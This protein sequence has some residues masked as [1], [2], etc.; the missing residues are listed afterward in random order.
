MS[1]VAFTYLYWLNLVSDNLLF[2]SIFLGMHLI[3]PG[4]CGGQIEGYIIQGE[5]P[6]ILE[7]VFENILF[8]ILLA[9]SIVAFASIWFFNSA[10][11]RARRMWIYYY[12][13]G[14]IHPKAF[15]L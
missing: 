8:G 2:F 7:K 9:L 14:Y 13:G 15:N 11:I 1:L 4:L 6:H 3:K 12:W 10:M 5:G